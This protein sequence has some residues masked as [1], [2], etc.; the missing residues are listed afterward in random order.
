MTEQLHSSNAAAKFS[1]GTT[2]ITPGA[3]ERLSRADVLQALRRHIRGDW[4]DVDAHDRRENEL[5]LHSGFRLFS[6]YRSQDGQ[7]FWVIT[8]ADR[9]ATTIL[10]PDEY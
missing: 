4:G 6:V 3:L 9:S 2:V 7:A 1:P 5:A 8:E 10:L